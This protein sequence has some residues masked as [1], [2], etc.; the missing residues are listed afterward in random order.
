MVVFWA[1]GPVWDVEGCFGEGWG[2]G[3]CVD[4]GG[5]GVWEGDDRVASSAEAGWGVLSACCVDFG[6]LAFRFGSLMRRGGRPLTSHGDEVVRLVGDRVVGEDGEAC[7][8]QVLVVEIGR[9]R[10]GE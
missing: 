6:V 2:V 9:E 8:E 7:M 3:C 4:Y 1:E 10:G 5:G